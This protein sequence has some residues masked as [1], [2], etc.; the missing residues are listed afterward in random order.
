[1]KTKL[2]AELASVVLL[3]IIV[4]FE[5][6]NYIRQYPKLQS[7][8]TWTFNESE[9]KSGDLLVIIQPAMRPI[10]VGHMCMI[11]RH[12]NQ[13]FVWDLNPFTATCSCFNP[14]YNFLCDNKGKHV[15][16]LHMKTE[17][18]NDN[19][20]STI[21]KFA[22]VRYEHHCIVE[23][24]SLFI[25]NCTGFPCIPV[26]SNHNKN[27]HYYCSDLIFD[28]FIE[29]NIMSTKP[30]TFSHHLFYPEYILRDPETIN[31]FM[32]PD[33]QFETPRRITLS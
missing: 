29:L 24:L 25:S 26:I 23:H 3:V 8:P 20:L 12:Y 22:D 33:H 21:K 14:M 31:A 9:M 32:M 1:M 6:R 15:H 4:F 19:L 2:L 7:Y 28:V 27:R 30:N 17:P 18:N 11:V 13:L 16:W 5:S 10:E